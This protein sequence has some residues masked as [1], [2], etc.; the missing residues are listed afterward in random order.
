MQLAV[1]QKTQLRKH[2]M[3]QEVKLVIW[4]AIVLMA[5]I[6]VGAR[7][8]TSSNSEV[9]SSNDPGMSEDNHQDGLEPWEKELS[10][11]LG[12]INFTTSTNGRLT[13]IRRGI[14]R[15]YSNPDAK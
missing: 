15:R 10:R 6:A 9:E 4:G 14:G 12:E 5:I 8:P 7:S 1:F 3:T 2:T 11:N 13:V